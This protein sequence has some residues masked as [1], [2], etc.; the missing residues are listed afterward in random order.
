MTTRP[1]IIGE[2]KA[3]DPV[4]EWLVSLEPGPNHKG[5]PEV[6][7]MTDCLVLEYGGHWHVITPG[8]RDGSVMHV[9]DGGGKV[10]ASATTKSI[11]FQAPSTVWGGLEATA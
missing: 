9:E 4:P 1:A 7:F 11:Y 8:D 6:I 3:G 2:F 5:T 10:T